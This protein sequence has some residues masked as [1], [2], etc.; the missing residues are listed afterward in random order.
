[1]AAT[2]RLDDRHLRKVLARV[3]DTLGGDV[4][5]I[6]REFAQ[7]MRVVTD[8]TF[9]KL[10]TG[11]SYRGV[12]WEY[13]APQYT[14]RSGVTVPAWGGVP[15]VR[16]GGSVKGRLRPSGAR[17]AAG[18]AIVQDSETLRGRAALVTKMRPQLMEL[19]PQG[20]DYAGVQHALRPF[21][22]FTPKD[23]EALLNIAI[24]RLKR[25]TG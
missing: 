4:R 13:F 12:T 9:E 20:V 2:I 14:R 6:F 21:L 24:R 7:Y 16:G 22:F 18:D 17:I 19:G 5:P 23:A 11:G 1:M 10:R 8:T 15:K 3:D 25:A